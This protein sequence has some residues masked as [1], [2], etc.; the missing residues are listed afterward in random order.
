MRECEEELGVRVRPS[1][2]EFAHVLHSHGDDGWVHFFFVCGSWDGTATNREPRK[3]AEPAWF[4]VHRL[5][6]DTVGYCARAVAHFLLGDPFSHH[7]TPTP[8]PARHPDRADRGV[9]HTGVVTT[10]GED[11]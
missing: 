8:F 9:G 10:P 1:E 3:H 7:R 2:L 6:R 5:P 11:E 4:P